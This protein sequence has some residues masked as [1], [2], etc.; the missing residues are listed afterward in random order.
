[1][2]MLDTSAMFRYR[3][4]F[5]IPSQ[6]RSSGAQKKKKSK[7]KTRGD[8]NSSENS[9]SDLQREETHR[10]GHRPDS[11]GLRSS[12][13]QA[14]LQ[15]QQQAAAPG[16]AGPKPPPPPVGPAFL[17]GSILNLRPAPRAAAPRRAPY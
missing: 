6:V 13:T 1:M 16:A 2:K 4:V 9:A 12:R 5:K 8:I 11:S 3:R 7:I 17:P 14:F 15:Q 10:G